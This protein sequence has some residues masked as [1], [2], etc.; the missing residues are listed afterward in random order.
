M[1]VN[2]EVV[3]NLKRSRE[4]VGELEPVYVTPDGEVV[5]GVH[6]LKANP[7]WKSVVLGVTSREQILLERIHRNLRRE[8]SKNERKRQL[9]ELALILEKRGV[10]RGRE[11]I[12]E[13]LKRVPFKD[14]YVYS[15]LP[16]RFKE[17]K[18][19]KPKVTFRKLYEEKEAEE[20][21]EAPTPPAKPKEEK[22]YLCPVCG[23]MLK[24]KG[25]LL[26]QA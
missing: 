20:K 4:Q 19:A 10:H 18:R 25:N 1:A 26:V 6:R 12:E 5:D 21:P 9:I 17:P 11:M 16:K 3:N 14:S 24:I 8:V 7:G 2:P 13:I 15:L 22:R 23:T